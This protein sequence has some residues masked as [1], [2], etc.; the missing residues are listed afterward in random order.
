[1]I[2]AATVRD[3]TGMMDVR[4]SVSEN[5]LTRSELEKLGIT[6]E[7]L[8]TMLTN[9]HDGWC[10]DSD[11]RVVAFS[12]ADREAGSVFALFVESEFEGRGFGTAL[13]DA[14]VSS[15]VAA[16]HRLI[17]LDTEPGSRAF[18]FYLSR[19]WRETGRAK[20]GDVTL[21]LEIDGT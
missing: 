2:R 12:M 15:L 5:A 7:S 13:L 19:G 16:G 3:V 9:T 18:R 17:T 11:G 14:A 20:R 8:E 6:E 10:A 4:M 1:M 21:S